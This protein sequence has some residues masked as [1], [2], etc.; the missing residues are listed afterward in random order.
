V[1]MRGQEA[2]PDQA[3]IRSMIYPACYQRYCC[4]VV[5]ACEPGPL[6]TPKDSAADGQPSTAP[7]A[8]DGAA[9]PTNGQAAPAAGPAAVGGRPKKDKKEKKQAA[10]AAATVE[11]TADLFGKALLQVGHL[12]GFW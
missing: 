10:Q 2:A 7:A 6:W 4:M 12:L 5:T 9:E 11:T 1:A 8:A 3:F